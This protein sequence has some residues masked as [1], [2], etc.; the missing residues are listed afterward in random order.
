MQ[1]PT[2]QSLSFTGA[3]LPGSMLGYQAGPRSGTA[4]DPHLGRELQRKY[5]NSHLQPHFW[6]E[7]PGCRIGDTISKRVAA[8]PCWG[9]WELKWAPSVVTGDMWGWKEQK[10]VFSPGAC[11]SHDCVP[12]QFIR[13][14]LASQTRQNKIL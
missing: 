9:F 5:G 12:G 1:R 4:A 8:L 7:P 13:H 10:E 3:R 14:Q 11:P 6:E 2:K